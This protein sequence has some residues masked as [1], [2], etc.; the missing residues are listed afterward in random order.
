MVSHVTFLQLRSNKSS[1]SQKWKT[2]G[3]WFLE[4]KNYS[5]NKIINQ[6]HQKGC[7]T[8]EQSRDK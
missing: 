5:S 3:Y 4:M 8:L 6:E 1:C 7:K 2:K